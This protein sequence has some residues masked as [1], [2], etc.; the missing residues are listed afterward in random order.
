MKFSIITPSFNQ[1]RF[2]ERTIDSVLAQRGEFE[3]EYVVVDGQSTDETLGVLRR[4]ADRLR[5]VSEPDRGQVDAVNKGIRMTS[6]EVVAWLNSDDTYEPGALQAVADALRSA[7]WCFG[8]CRIVDEHDREIRH[9]ISRYKA[10]Q[11]RRYGLRR[12]L[13]RNFIPQPATFFRRELL[14]QAGALDET[15]RFAMDYDLWL[16]F[17][18]IAPPVFV[19]RPLATFRWHGAS[20]TGAHY[21]TGAWEAFRIACRHARGLERLALPGHLARYAAQVAVYGALASA[22]R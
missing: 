6:G 8:T 2:I 18:R 16:R 21:R 22:G 10:A 7:A 14:S 3:L 11:S 20:K 17:A 5:F 1:G 15:L 13:G 12:L 9:G 4:Y 19:H